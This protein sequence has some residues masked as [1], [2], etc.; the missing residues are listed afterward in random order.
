[1]LERVLWINREADTIVTYELNAHYALPVFKK[2]SEIEELLNL[3]E[4]ETVEY[5]SM[6]MFDYEDISESSKQ[7][8]ESRWTLM[9]NLVT[10]EPDIYIS[11]RR[12]EMIEKITKENLAI[13]KTI[14]KLLR[15]YWGNGKTKSAFLP[16]IYKRGGKGNIKSCGI[17]KRG[18]PSKK[19][20]G[21]LTN[22]ETKNELNQDMIKQDGINIT[23]DSRDKIIRGYKKNYKNKQEMPYVQAYQRTLE[24]HFSKGYYKNQNGVIVP[25][26]DL[27]NVPSLTQ[28]KYW[29]KKSLSEIETN[30]VRKGETKHELYHRAVVGESTIESFGP[31]RKFQI[32]ATIAD[33]YLVNRLNK[34]YIIGRPVVYMVVDVFSRMIVGFYVGLEGPSW[35]GAMMALYNTTRNKVELCKEFGIN[36]EEGEWDCCYMP[37]SLTVDRGEMESTKPLN[38]IQN[39]GVRIDI[40]PPYRADWKGIIEQNFKR[41]NYKTLHWLKGT[42]KKEYRVRGEEDYRLGAL[43]DLEE[44]TKVII[45]SIIYFNGRYMDY[46]DK[47][48][49]MIRDDV[50]PIPKNLWRWGIANRSGLLKS[51]PEDV[52][53]FNLMPSIECSITYRGLLFQKRRYSCEEAVNSGIFERARKNGR[54]KVKISYDPRNIDYVYVHEKGGFTK[55]NLVDDIKR[56]LYLEEVACA[57]EIEEQEAV[58]FS[59]TDIQNTAELNASIDMINEEANKKF[60]E[61]QDS[62]NKRIKNIKNNRKE[63]REFNRENEAWEL[64]KQ[65]NN[66]KIGESININED[67]DEDEYL[68]EPQYLELLKFDPD[69]EDNHGK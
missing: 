14:Y 1:M 27:D 64:E 21:I 38:L 5:N 28:F 33:I 20:L 29:G 69:K 51:Y 3:K 9:E 57:T 42:V 25:I 8:I 54:I 34:N 59:R 26:I 7:I 24:E 4:I 19:I 15:Q 10:C 32:D 49:Q 62:N 37:D 41:L 6:P 16:N 47:D 31:G 36:I 12:G 61:T 2:L 18:R 35:M 60:K 44:F 50:I 17:K 46:Y 43:L 63:E 53:K 13:K 52:I 39:L 23:D 48:E 65:I 58:D 56:N 45:L 30:K 22:D 68:P 67:I 11:K 66:A 40:L 55:Y